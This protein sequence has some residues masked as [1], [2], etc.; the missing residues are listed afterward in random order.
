M[1]HPCED[2]DKKYWRVATGLNKCRTSTRCHCREVSRIPHHPY[3][4]AVAKSRNPSVTLPKRGQ[5]RHLI[6]YYFRQVRACAWKSCRLIYSRRQ[7]FRILILN[8][9]SNGLF[10]Q[11]RAGSW[12]IL[13]CILKMERGIHTAK[14]NGC[15]IFSMIDYSACGWSIELKFRI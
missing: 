1:W 12:S 5:K 6:S 2:S 15:L 10:W 8:S 3:Y 14:Q 7:T 4:L 13:D 9:S 11:S